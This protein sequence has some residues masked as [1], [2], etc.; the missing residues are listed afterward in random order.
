MT[1]LSKHT[2]KRCLT[3][4]GRALVEGDV[5]V[6]FAIQPEIQK[7]LTKSTERGRMNILVRISVIEAPSLKPFFYFT[8]ESEMNGRRRNSVR[9]TQPGVLPCD[10]NGLKVSSELDVHMAAVAEFQR[11]VNRLWDGN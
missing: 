11:L 6:V 5:G 7:R 2:V 3:S 1:Q 9:S 8:I 10:G 4:F